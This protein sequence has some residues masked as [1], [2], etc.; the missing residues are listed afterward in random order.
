MRVRAPP[1]APRRPAAPGRLCPRVKAEVDEGYR[2]RVPAFR[3]S[4]TAAQ[5]LS[6]ES[7]PAGSFRAEHQR[8]RRAS[9][10]S[11]WKGGDG[12]REHERA[13][14]NVDNQRRRHRGPGHGVDVAGEQDP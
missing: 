11:R 7:R 13:E 14:A 10:V 12:V 4:T 3:A 9:R 6:S 2:A 8:R 5:W 1:A